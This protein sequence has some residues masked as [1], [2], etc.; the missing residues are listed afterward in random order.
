M[1]GTGG[2]GEDVDMRRITR[3]Q[4]DDAGV[5]GKY[6]AERG[7]RLG[8]TKVSKGEMGGGQEGNAGGV[9]GEKGGGEEVGKEGGT[10]AA[11]GSGVSTEK[12]VGGAM[13]CCSGRASW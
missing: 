10:R 13:G 3:L 4:G 6:R 8:D 11:A 12:C 9:R 1:A 5:D 7:D 2:P